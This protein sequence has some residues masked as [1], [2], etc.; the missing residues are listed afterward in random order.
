VVRRN[1]SN[2]R[3]VRIASICSVLVVL[4]GAVRAQS[5]TPGGMPPPPGMSQAQSAAMRFP[6]SVRVG[7]LLGRD[8][9]RPVE[10][11]DVLGH[12][13]EVV[14]DSTGQIL[15]VI[16]F[17]GLFGFGS[18]PIAVPVDAMVL[19]GQDMEVV[20]FTPDQLGQFPTF[21]SSGA[22]R[23]PDDAVIKVGLAKPSH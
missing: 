18:R 3:P 5:T 16:D 17:G 2:M 22:T 8:V 15:V 9:L 20:A 21:S 13:R 19:L 4:A 14:S 10:S 7:D 23:V 6:Q 12:V 11:Q 1:M